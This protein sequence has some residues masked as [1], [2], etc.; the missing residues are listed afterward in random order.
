[1]YVTKEN[2]PREGCVTGIGNRTDDPSISRMTFDQLDH[3]HKNGSRE[4]SAVVIIGIYI[5]LILFWLSLRFARLHPHSV[6]MPLD[7][8]NSLRPPLVENLL[9]LDGKVEIK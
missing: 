7:G 5:V 4:P 6:R 1:M 8:S 3:E 2:T 9:S